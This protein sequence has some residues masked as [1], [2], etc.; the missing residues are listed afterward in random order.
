M[1]LASPPLAPA[2]DG[3]TCR[4][5]LRAEE[6]IAATELDSGSIELLSWN[7][8]KA[9]H[10]RSMDDLSRFAD[11]KDLVLIQEAPLASAL[12]GATAN[13]GYWSFAPGYRTARAM[14]GVLTLSGTEPLAH[15]TLTTREPWLRTP[16]ATDVVQFGLTETRETLVV[17][18]IHAINFSIGVRAFTAQLEQVRHVLQDHTGPIILS[19]DFNTWRAHRM[20]VL[21]T[22]ADEM[23]LTP[24]TFAI[25]HRTT[26]F[27][28]ALDHIYTRGL[29]ARAATTVTV[30][31]SDH[32][33]M[34]V[35]LSL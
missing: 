9:R 26:A 6:N 5:V 20:E 24:L 25:D 29:K 13:T 19:G 34:S 2:K 10:P 16:K 17:V 27:S 22:L 15:C 18:N 31:S 3:A 4:R 1:T 30:E 12:T 32:N 11:G 8:Q 23:G 33:P 21:T 7:I 28:H 14:T 35:E